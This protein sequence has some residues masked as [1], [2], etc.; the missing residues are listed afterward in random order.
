MSHAHAPITPTPPEPA[1]TTRSGDAA[2]IPTKTA[3]DMT[4]R[5]AL[6]VL[7]FPDEFDLLDDGQMYVRR[8]Y[9]QLFEQRGWLTCR[10]VM[11]DQSVLLD[12]RRHDHENCFVDFPSRVG[13]DATVRGF[14]KRHTTRPRKCRGFREGGKQPVISPGLSEALA[15]AVC[16]CNNV[17]VANV[18]AAGQH[19]SNDTPGAI[20]SFFISEQI[21]GGLPADR[22][23][24]SHIVGDKSSDDGARRRAL[25]AS[26][27][28][29]ARSLHAAHLFHRDLYWCHFFVR[30]PATGQFET[31]LIDLHR[32]H[33]AQHGQLRWR[34]KDIA[35][36][37]VSAPPSVSGDDLHYWFAR[38]RGVQQLSTHD[39]LL[40][41]ATGVR[42]WFY[43]W[44]DGRG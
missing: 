29:A 6:T 24:E 36:F 44:K 8:D 14:L 21:V 12:R 17:P 35:Q 1:G 2:V 27:A 18:I 33:R 39:R 37:R 23:W 9:R 42:A 28:H 32:L 4:H 13:H 16:Q 5:S 26:L 3:G 41:A 40:C 30:E 38:Y 19:V 7:R 22:F 10:D 25:L 15:V 31:Y 43:H 20:D 11:V 34:V